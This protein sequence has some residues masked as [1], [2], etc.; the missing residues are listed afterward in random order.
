[1]KIFYLMDALNVGGLER[2][3]LEIIQ[4]L[5]E[6]VES[7]LCHIYPEA[8]LAPKF[9]ETGIPVFS[10]DAKNKYPFV[11]VW[12]RLLILLR[13][14]QPDIIH[15][16]GLYAL[17]IGRLAGRWLQIP[18]IDGFTN[19]PYTSEHYASIPPRSRWKL[20]VIQEADRYSLRWVTHVISVSATIRDRYS[21]IL[22]VDPAKVSVIYRGRNPQPFVASNPVEVEQVRN[23]L[24]I[25]AQ[26]TILL[27]V[28]RLIPRKGQEELIRSI[29]RIQQ[30]C[31]SVRLLI[32][33]EG[34]HR[35]SL[36]A[37]VEELGLTREV[38]LLG[39]RNDIA[40]LLQIADVFVFPSHFEGH[41]GALVE[42]M[43]AACPIIASDIP[44][45]RE[46]IVDQETGCLVPL[47]SPEGIA[48]GV[49]RMVTQ[50]KAAQQ[51]AQKAR[52]VALERFHIE[53]VATQY[54]E[55]YQRVLDQYQ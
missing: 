32:A 2:S 47:H 51:M 12:Q 48:Q 18:V 6:H 11:E 23:H 14:E 17:L 37:L 52:V 49:I 29:P 16:A 46:T 25:D 19:E 33:G 21:Q 22:G 3:M 24:K 36:A 41:P 45:H 15:I 54:A 5:P 9:K 10:L 30:V 28:A 40:T 43:F 50:P 38:Q 1:M 35:S 44:V 13:Q 27:N 20:R 34:H 4:H 8:A 53:Q 42:A 55:T 7:V 31:G 26:T 39:I